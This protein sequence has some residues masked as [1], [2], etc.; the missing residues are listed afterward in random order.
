VAEIR[1]DFL[2]ECHQLVVA[3][4]EQEAAAGRVARQI[5]GKQTV[6]AD[7]HGLVEIP[8]LEC[9]LDFAAAHAVPEF[10]DLPGLDGQAEQQSGEQA[11]GF[12][13]NC[14]GVRAGNG[15]G[16]SIPQHGCVTCR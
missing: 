3:E 10:T 12:R 11:E 6:V 8:G 1:L 7:R 15:M 14:H 16:C 4:G 13:A 9:L 5:V 2:V